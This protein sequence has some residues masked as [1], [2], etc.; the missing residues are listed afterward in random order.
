M[1]VRVPVKPDLLRWACLRNGNE[2]DVYFEKFAKLDAWI[3]GESEP[4]LKQLESFAKATRTP[5]GFF[6][7]P[8]PPEERVPIPDFRVGT[9]QPSL[10]PSPDLLDT[11]YLCQQRQEWYAE[12]AR[13]T[14]QAPLAFVGS[15]HI[16]DDVV[17]TASRIREALGFTLEA[18]RRSSTWTDAL[19][20]FI[21]LADSAGVLVMCSGVV[22]SNNSRKLDPAEFRGFAIAD[23]LAPVIFIN[24]ADTKAAQMFT[25]AHELAHIWIRQSGVSNPEV[26][27]SSTNAVE[28]WCNEVAAELLVPL[29]ELKSVMDYQADVHPEMQRLARVFKVSTLVVLRRLHDAGRLSADEMWE[30]YRDELKRLMELPSTSG[31]NFYLTQPVRVSKRFARA[32]VV[33][34]L[35]GNTLYRDAFRMLG[36]SKTSTFNELGHSLG[37]I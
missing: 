20:Q 3:R 25:L 9:G 34:T 14:G 4:T 5:V 2:P 24:G 33:S 37:V 27:R 21:E 12:H 36:V 29:A 1:T 6:F 26:V 31:G 19:R 11:V 16:A 10:R 28:R 30:L 13:I 32:L 35:E 7:L 17:K 8:A 23:E 22:G 18:R 15:A